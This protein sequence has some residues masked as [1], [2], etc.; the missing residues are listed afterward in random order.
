M[1][2]QSPLAARVSEQHLTPAVA[3]SVKQRPCQ[4]AHPR[5]WP[6][7]QSIR[8]RDFPNSG[9]RQRQYQG[10]T[11]LYTDI[12]P[13]IRVR[14]FF[15]MHAPL[16]AMLLH[17]L[18]AEWHTPLA[19]ERVRSVSRRCVPPS[20]TVRTLRWL[21]FHRGIL[22]K[23]AVGVASLGT[24]VAAPFAASCRVVCSRR[25]YRVHHARKNRAGRV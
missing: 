22:P 25:C 17:G 6:R 11:I 3:P 13:R 1:H 10:P 4:R 7:T 2:R 18:C 14:P 15:P 24:A 8:G 5:S 9:S 23:K 21:A 12:R 16:C 19:A 20:R